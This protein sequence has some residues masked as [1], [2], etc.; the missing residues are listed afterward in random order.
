MRRRIQP[1][2]SISIL[3]RMIGLLRLYWHFSGP[4]I[5]SSSYQSR[6]NT[7]SL[8]QMSA[9]TTGYDTS[10]QS[11]LQIL[12]SFRKCVRMAVIP[13]WL[14]KYYFTTSWWLH[15]KPIEAM[16]SS[17][18]LKKMCR[19]P[20]TRRPVCISCC[21]WFSAFSRSLT[22]LSPPRHAFI[23]TYVSTT[24]VIA[25]RSYTK[26]HSLSEKRK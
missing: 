3:S 22:D 18:I 16:L 9:V 15:F 17:K 8:L 12:L 7:F 21:K 5:E 23:F 26:A 4:H 19:C 11:H 1:A 20:D 6:F 25:M 24:F 10:Y 14:M 13:K 2:T